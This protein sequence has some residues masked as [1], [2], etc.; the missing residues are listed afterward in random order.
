[1]IEVEVSGA[2]VRGLNREAMREFVRSAV[3]AV[4]RARA[5]SFRVSEVSVAFVPDG[6]M[7]RLNRTFRRKNSTTDVLTFP[8]DESY[9]PSGGRFLGDICI[10]VDQAKRQAAE[11]R[12]SV[13]TEVRYLLLHGVLHAYGY[14][15]ETD[16]GEMNALEMKLRGRLGLD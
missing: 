13:A 5:A 9:D 3:K 1:M 11:Q 16:K 2:A 14:D 6:E 8:G 15:H 12:H 10:S 7:Q 4:E